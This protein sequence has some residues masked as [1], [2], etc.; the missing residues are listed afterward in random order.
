MFKHIMHIL[1]ETPKI[2]NYKVIKNNH[3]QILTTASVACV[4]APMLRSAPK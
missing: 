3:T 4:K 2:K 1:K